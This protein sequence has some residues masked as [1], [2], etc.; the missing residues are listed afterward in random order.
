MG[1]KAGLLYNMGSRRRAGSWS[2]AVVV[3]LGPQPPPLRLRWPPRRRCPR[4]LKRPH[5]ASSCTDSGSASRGRS[6]RS[7]V[8]TPPNR[9]LNRAQ[10]ASLRSGSSDGLPRPP[11]CMRGRASHTRSSRRVWQQKI[12]KR[13]PS[14]VMFPIA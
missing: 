3:A 11:Q 4:R 1:S 13:I 9:V 7:P 5:A 8:G 12:R 10:S 14:L 2:A 6:A